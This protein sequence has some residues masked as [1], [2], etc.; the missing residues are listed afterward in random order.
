MNMKKKSN[1]S[2][3]NME[4]EDIEIC[5]ITFKLIFLCNPH[6]RSGFEGL[7]LTDIRIPLYKY[8]YISF[9]G[10]VLDIDLRCGTFCTFPSIR[11]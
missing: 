8:S 9:C 5:K 6:S 1:F 2:K 3:R 10:L 4:R 11:R 7:E